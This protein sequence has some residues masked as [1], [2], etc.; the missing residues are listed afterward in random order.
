[1][2]DLKCTNRTVRF[3]SVRWSGAK[4]GQDCERG[5][6]LLIIYFSYIDLDSLKF[7]QFFVWIQDT[8]GIKE[9]SLSLITLIFLCCLVRAHND[10]LLFSRLIYPW[11]AANCFFKMSKV[12]NHSETDPTVLK[13]SKLGQFHTR[14]GSVWQV[15]H[16]KVIQKIK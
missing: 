1:M 2:D 14:V 6:L 10:N 8:H 11:Q 4:N 12:K 15:F 7:W 13:R 3:Q 5:T 9:V 16:T